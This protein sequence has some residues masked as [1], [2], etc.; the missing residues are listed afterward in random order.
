MPTCE[1]TGP[2]VALSQSPTFFPLPPLPYPLPITNTFS[3]FIT[4]SFQEYYKWSHIICKLL[5]FTF[6]FF[7]IQCNS[8]EIYPGCCVSQKFIVP[9]CLTI[10]SL[11]DICI[12]S[13]FTINIHY[14]FLCKHKSFFI[15]D[16]CPGV[17]LLSHGSCIYSLRN[18]QTTFQRGCIHIIVS[19]AV[20]E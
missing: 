15:W 5:K 16:K 3:I 2:H 20:C 12:V 10:C 11:K 9:V 6:F 18:C 13:S 7:H 8:L 17:Q 4:L 19:P 14:R 1:C